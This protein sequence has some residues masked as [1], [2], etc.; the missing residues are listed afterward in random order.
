[1]RNHEE[2]RI[3]C[4]QAAAGDISDDAFRDL[5]EHLIDCKDCHTL[6]SDF[7]QVSAL[8][9]SRHG[10]HI[11]HLPASSP[12]EMRSRFIERAR[13]EGIPLRSPWIALPHLSRTFRSRWPSTTAVAI[14][15][16]MAFAVL[17][18]G[19]PLKIQLGQPSAKQFGSSVAAADSPTAVPSSEHEVVSRLQQELNQERERTRQ[20]EIEI[21]QLKHQRL[22]LER[23]QEETA[24]KLSS[25][26]GEVA[27]LREVSAQKASELLKANK[28][29]E[30]EHSVEVDYMAEL[31]ERQAQVEDLRAK[32]SARDAELKH[33][34]ELLT[35]S[36]Q[37]RE[38]IVARNLHIVDVHDSNGDG[39]H[40]R[41]FGRIFYI[42]GKSLVFYAYDLQEA[43]L[44]DSKVSF[45]VWGTK[46]DSQKQARNLGMLRSEDSG[47]GRWE[48]TCDDPGVLTKINTVFV[49][50]EP[51]HK[52]VSRPNGKRILYAFLNGTPNH[53]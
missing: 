16:L 24:K 3:L 32:L 30:S 25:L 6:L 42:E 17:K 28:Q 40:Q 48:L 45:H 52:D 20:R 39:D 4:A 5:R 9:L 34:R 15:L 21:A 47:A 10:S 38:L 41:P 49:T 13:R 8:A 22:A 7:I 46:L 26:E 36:N 51:A 33:N 27:S 19:N 53:P 43:G 31:A 1:M 2:Y 44:P 12:S 11:S 23:P 37:G 18:I 29:L 14:V 50:A 35:A